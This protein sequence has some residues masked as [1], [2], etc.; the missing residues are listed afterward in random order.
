MEGLGNWGRYHF[1]SGCAK[2][3][4]WTWW[5]V[6]RGLYLCC[7]FGKKKFFLDLGGFFPYNRACSFDRD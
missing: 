7:I 1:D 5:A 2:I 6:N 4:A 3:I